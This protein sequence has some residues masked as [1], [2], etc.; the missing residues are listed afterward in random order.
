MFV[1]GIIFE[2]HQHCGQHFSFAGKCV[3]QLG[4]CINEFIAFLHLT[5]REF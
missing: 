3:P 4:H 5:M 2:V 1:P